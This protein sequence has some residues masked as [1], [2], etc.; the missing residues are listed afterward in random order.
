[1]PKGLFTQSAC[2]LL[3]RETSL[4]EIAPLLSEFKIAKRNELADNPNFGGPSFLLPFRPEV[5]GYLVAEVRNMKWPDHMGDTKAEVELFGAWTMG[6]FGPFTFPGNLQRAREQLWAWPEG[7]EIAGQHSAFIQIKAS[8]S[9]GAD[10]GA[11]VLPADYDAMPEIRFV[12]QVALAL[13][14]HPAALGYFNPNGEVLASEE[15]MKKSLEYHEQHAIPPFD[16]WSN[17]RMF[18]PGNGWIIMDT[19]GMGQF[20]RPDLEGC[21]PAKTYESGEIS[22][23]LRNCCL[24]LLKNGEVIKHKDTMNGPGKINWR[25]YHMENPICSPPRRTIR[26]FPQDGSK[27]PPAM[28]PEEPKPTLGQRLGGLFGRGK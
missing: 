18:N 13:L 5:N 15:V 12:T 14:K 8:Y 10:K 21:F 25:G 3:S 23:F 7:K 2:V 4:D 16:L 22:Y 1:M 17:I 24:Y 27:P 20:D 19:V 28:L 6:F 26:W 9:L 11:K